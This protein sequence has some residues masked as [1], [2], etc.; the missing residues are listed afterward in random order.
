MRG[1]LRGGWNAVLIGGVLLAASAVIPIQTA[2]A[3]RS[4]DIYSPTVIGDEVAR[5]GDQKFRLEQAMNRSFF[6]PGCVSRE[7]IEGMRRAYEAW[8]ADWQPLFGVIYRAFDPKG[9][10]SISVCCG[11]I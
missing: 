9:S 3:Q 4:T 6:R 8:L 5:L 2:F 7:F 10:D 1:F 11:V